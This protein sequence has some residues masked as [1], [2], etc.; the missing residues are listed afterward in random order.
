M[1]GRMELA[2]RLSERV[3]IEHWQESRDAAGL[4]DGAWVVD[5]VVPAHVA[6]DAAVNG[7]AVMGDAERTVARL[8]VTLRAPQRLGVTSRLWWRGERLTVLG[9]V[10]DP[11]QPDRLVARCRSAG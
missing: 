11:E 6:L 10:R 5:G 3:T 7:D 8:R 2:G 1:G 4:S 9:V